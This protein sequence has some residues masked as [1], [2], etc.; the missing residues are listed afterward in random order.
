MK[1]SKNTICVLGMGYVGLPLAVEFGK[2]FN[3]IG[4]D[5]NRKRIERLKKFIDINGEVTTKEIKKSNKLCFSSK[6]KDLLNANIF[7]ITVPTPINKRNKPDL[8]LLKSATR[9]V[10]NYLKKGD[11]VIYEST[12]YPGTTDEVCVPILEN[13]SKLVFKEDF[14]CGYSPERINPGDKK[15]TLKN[16]DKIVS[17]SNKATLKKIYQL[18]NLI[19][20][21]DVHKTSSI[22]VAE[23]A[24]VIEN[25]Q[26]DLNIALVNELSIIFNKLDID[27]KEVLDAAKTKWNFIPFSPGLVG[28]HCIGV[29]PYYLTYKAKS[30]G[31][32]PKVILAGRSI[33]N[34]MGS[35]IVS[36]LI[37]KLKKKQMLRKRIKVLIMGL[38]FKENCHDIRNSGS[39][40]ILKNL[41]K[42]HF[43]TDVYDPWADDK[44]AYRYYN[45]KLK[46]KIERQTY[47]AVIISVGHKIFKEMGIRKIKSF[48]KSK[49]VIFD[50]KRIFN[51]EEVDLFL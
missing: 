16:I 19:I 39:A 46:G 13:I 22:R 42:E 15:R 36:R 32:S 5:I 14:N 9:L 33:N 3:T 48:C 25:T 4:F 51:N 17:G 23:A 27:S 18:Y 45:I 35:Y 1:L 28:G 10:G 47:D 43:D 37:E 50:V 21:A 30:V 44:D 29:D 41:K 20:Q 49:N 8:S 38:A 6:E 26:R 7:I 31:Y 34:R 40:S 11:I 2:I 24:K 12:V